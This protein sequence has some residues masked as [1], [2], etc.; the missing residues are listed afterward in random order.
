MSIPP[1]ASYYNVHAPTSLP[2][3]GLGGVASHNLTPDLFGSPAHRLDQQVSPHSP[4]AHRPRAF[5]FPGVPPSN[6]MDL[7]R[8]ECGSDPRTTCMIKVGK[9]FQLSVGLC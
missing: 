5:P 8:I 9:F 6:V 1:P 7:D 4:A 2:V 3:D